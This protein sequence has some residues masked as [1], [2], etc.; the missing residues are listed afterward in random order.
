MLSLPLNNKLWDDDIERSILT[1]ALRDPEEVKKVQGIIT[2]KDFYIKKNSYLFRVIEK[3]WQDKSI[4]VVDYTYIITIIKAQK[5]TA[6]IATFIAELMDEAR[7][8]NCVYAAKKVKELS[9]RREIEKKAKLIQKQVYDLTISTLS[10]LTDSK[11]N[12]ANIKITNDSEIDSFADF[13]SKCVEVYEPLKEIISIQGVLTGYYAVDD[14][15]CGFQ[16]GD[17]IIIAGRPSM[18]KTAFI[19]N[20]MINQCREGIKVGFLSLEMSKQKIH[21]RINSI[22]IRMNS[23]KFRRGGITKQEFEK[24]VVF[25]EESSKWDL[26]IDDTPY[27][28]EEEIRY[29]VQTLVQK[30]G[31]E[32][33]YIDYLQLI[34]SAEKHQ[35]KDLEIG[36]IARVLKAIAKEFNIPIV[37]LSQLNRSLEQRI[38]KRP[39]LSDLRESGAIEQEADIIVF[40]YRPVVYDDVSNFTFKGAA[41]IKREDIENPKADPEMVKAFE[42]ETEIIVSKNRDGD[43]GKVKI[44][45]IKEFTLFKEKDSGCGL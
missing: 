9:I 18:G 21:N 2:S 7:P 22:G 28:T 8:A 30:H 45:F 29:K 38:S 39:V 34:K 3:G 12:F 32:I 1:L 37:V 14:L 24:L 36:E 44:D 25:M 23:L 31:V 11:N 35:R 20:T 10:L 42:R 43:T 6:M 33:C 16:N 40:L 41:D 17:L 15:I 27:V 19:V 13:Q 26:F 4:N 5:K